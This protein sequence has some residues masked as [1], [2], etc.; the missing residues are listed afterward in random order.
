MRDLFE[1]KRITPML[2]GASSG[3]FDDAEYLY[4]IKFDGERAIAYLD[5]DSTELRNKRNKRMLPIFPELSN[6]HEQSKERCILDGEF[7]CLVNG[8]PN[9]SQVQRRSLLTNDFK[10]KLAAKSHPVTFVAF[11]ILYLKNQD[12]TV[13]PLIERK[14]ILE[15][16]IAQNE[17]IAVSHSFESGGTALYNLMVQQGLEGIV[18]KKKDSQYYFDKRTKEWIK[19]KNMQDDDFIV[20]G[21]IPK[22]NHM[23]SI[24]LGKYNQAEQLVYKGHVTL[25]V[26]GLDFRRI[27]ESK[28]CEPLFSP[29]PK[30]NEDAIWISP[31]L[32]CTVEFMEHTANGGM[33]QP[34]FKGLRQDKQSL[35]I[36][37]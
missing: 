34:V 2:I 1:E 18:A 23:N 20:C 25:G 15:K 32:V 36:R 8:K 3:P 27:Q 11:D 10:I 16:N 4:E 7:I 21:W 9:F 13:R 33:R 19:I 12:L 30:G 35:E 29:V 14:Q 26:N 5:A 28:R 22:D 31:E 24:I 17:R 37:E 6:I